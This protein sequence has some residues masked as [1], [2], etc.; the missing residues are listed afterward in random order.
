M[1]QLVV[2]AACPDDMV[3]LQDI[4]RRASWS[5]LDDRPVLTEHPEFLEL[6]DAGVLEGRTRVALMAD[7]AVGF[8]TLSLDASVAELEDLFVDPD[9]MR[10]GVAS[11]LI[12]DAKIQTRTN[13]AARIEVD[14]NDHAMRFYESAGFISL[15]RITL[16]HGT[17]TRMV[18]LVD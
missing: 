12:V 14:A 2:R 18:A 6:S 17:A 9:W 11:A 7:A 15:A 13:G 5:N 8:A 3:A 4:F 16:P 1:S 10:R